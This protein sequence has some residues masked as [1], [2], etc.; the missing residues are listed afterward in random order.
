MFT[1]SLGAGSNKEVGPEGS[2]P[3]VH[4]LLWRGYKEAE[5][6]DSLVFEE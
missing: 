2:S 4:P 6:R 5:S 1:W 3:K